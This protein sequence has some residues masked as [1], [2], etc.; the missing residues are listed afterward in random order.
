[1]KPLLF[2]DVDGV[3]NDLGYPEREDGRRGGSHTR[4][5]LLTYPDPAY[6]EFGWFC[7]PKYMR[8]LITDL[9]ERTEFR[10][11]TA[12]GESVVEIER[13]VGLPHREPVTGKTYSPRSAHWKGEETWA[14]AHQAI[15][16]E[17]AVYWIEDFN[18][19]VYSMTHPGIVLIDTVG[20]Y[21]D[22][23]RKRVL[24]KDDLPKELTR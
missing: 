12:W 1:V 5:V 18:G 4:Q 17:R 20:R 10:W 9:M 7:T 16:Q 14:M 11:L 19:R 24:M 2:C 13:E 8:A 21:A 3:V 15:A 22:G 23:K 6:P